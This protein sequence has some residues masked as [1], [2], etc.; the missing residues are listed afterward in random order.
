MQYVPKTALCTISFELFVCIIWE[1]AAY[2]EH[3][4]RLHNYA[5]EI[6]KRSA[7]ME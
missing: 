3:E 1:Q 6:E 4:E 5:T 7:A 2:D